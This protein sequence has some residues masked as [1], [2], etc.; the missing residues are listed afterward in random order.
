MRRSMDASE[1]HNRRFARDKFVTLISWTHANTDLDAT[2]S[3]LYLPN[4]M[5]FRLW[6]KNQPIATRFEN[7]TRWQ[8]I[9]LK[10]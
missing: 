3:Q 5:P 6:L 2:M 1:R 4:P 8:H 10:K 7:S 9:K